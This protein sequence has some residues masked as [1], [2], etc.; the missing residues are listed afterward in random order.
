ME[1]LEKCGLQSQTLSHV[2]NKDES[3]W[4][5]N[6][7]VTS[8]PNNSTLLYIAVEYVK[9]EFKGETNPNISSENFMNLQHVSSYDPNMN[10]LADYSTVYNE[11]NNFNPVVIHHLVSANSIGENSAFVST[12]NNNSALESVPTVLY[13]T[14]ISGVGEEYLQLEN[15]TNIPSVQ[16]L[17][18][19]DKEQGVEILIT[20][21]ATGIS[22]SVNTQELLVEQEELLESLSPGPL[23]DSDLLTID[24]ST[25]KNNLPDDLINGNVSTSDGNNIVANFISDFSGVKDEFED[26]EYL[27]LRKKVLPDE[28]ECEDKLLSKVFNIIDKPIP[29]R[30]RA[31]LPETYLKITKVEEDWAVFAKKCIRKRTQFGPVQGIL[32]N[33]EEIITQSKRLELLLKDAEDKILGLDISD[34]EQSNWMC[35][36]RKAE[37]YEEQNMVVSQLEDSLYFTVIRN[38]L[39]KQELKVGYSFTY[40][41]QYNL[42][43]L[44]KKL[45]EEQWPCFECNEHFPTSQELQN[46]LN[47]HDESGEP[48]K[49]RKKNWKSKKKL[50]KVSITEAWQCKICDQVFNPPKLSALKQHYLVKH[51]GPD[52]N[53]E[54]NFVVIRNYK[55]DKCNLVF[56]TENLYRV[57]NLLHNQDENDDDFENENCYMCPAC[58]RKFPTQRQLISHVSTHSL[59]KYKIIPERFQCPH[60]YTSYPLRERL[61]RHMLIHGPEESKP[62]QCNECKKRFM[63]NS[64]LICHLK[65]HVSGESIYQCPICKDRFEHVPKLKLHVQKHC[66]NNTYTCPHCN[67]KFKAYSIIRKHIRAFHS[68]QKHT[69]QHCSKVFHTMDKLKIHLLK[70]SDHR[71]FLCSHCGKQFK[72]KDKLTEHCKRVHSEERENNK[73]KGMQSEENDSKKF[74]PKAEPTDFHRFIYKCHPCLIG[75]KRRGMLVNHLA[76]R[77]P[78]ISLDSVPELNLPILRTTKDYYCQ[79]CDKIY[80]SSS[81]RKLHILKNHPG[82]ALPVSNRKQGV[83]QE[84][85]GLPNLSF[86]QTVGSVTTSPQNCKWCHKQYASKAKLLHHQRKEHNGCLKQEGGDADKSNKELN[87]S[88]EMRG[89][90]EQEFEIFKQS[91]FVV[92]DEVFDANAE[93]FV[94]DPEP[95]NHF[96]DLQNI[97]DNEVFNQNETFVLPNSHLYRLLTNANNMVPPR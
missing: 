42:P 9:D 91:D 84:V 47:I 79:Y 68:E 80:K 82:A 22:Y 65:T 41:N 32:K 92:T 58:N 87:V 4:A 96:D 86:S 21:Q 10:S 18:S 93:E 29:S 35:F 37:S 90:E 56:Q 74:V 64:A 66:V 27:K 45:T 88:G 3:E 70:Y 71:E 12:Q 26:D 61:Q 94:D 33:R 43:V 60:C 77:H 2:L 95:K 73:P 40:A 75:F 20:D 14:T 72:R 78:D 13:D 81:K 54:E 19:V 34:E 15:S 97:A 7:I 52:D 55:C 24:E 49:C 16:S 5:H 50:L 76:K 11:P 38:I 59:P 53:I 17:P 63:N 57:H 6:S 46:H 85:A 36:I 67:K 51:N 44:E 28:L 62:L 1:S 31:T 25:L 69:C 30:A 48:T 89:N 8:N 83:Y 23:L 39:P